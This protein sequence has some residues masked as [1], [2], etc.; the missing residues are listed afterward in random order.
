MRIERNLKLMAVAIAIATAVVACKKDIPNKTQDDDPYEHNGDYN[1][2]GQGGWQKSNDTNKLKAEIIKLEQDSANKVAQIEQLKND[3]VKKVAEIQQLSDT[4]PVLKAKKEQYKT[5]RENVA[6]ELRPNT[7][8]RSVYTNALT[9]ECYISD[10]W[11]AMIEAYLSGEPRNNIKDSAKLY[12]KNID[13][14]KLG[15]GGEYEVWP[16]MFNPV[17]MK[18]LEDTCKYFLNLDSILIPNITA[19]I[20]KAI[21]DKKAAEQD[22]I[23]IPTEIAR[24]E[25]EIKEIEKELAKLREE[26]EKLREEAN[27][28]GIKE[29]K[30]K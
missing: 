21:N 4:I 16:A 2:N 18:K 6:N 1:Q 12:L 27:N 25:K 26:L 22:L 24:I 5:D 19:D 15:L 20:K 14:F 10:Q 13:L 9:Y 7:N 28:V 17:S 11:H 30:M 23:N 29:P 3:S 8:P